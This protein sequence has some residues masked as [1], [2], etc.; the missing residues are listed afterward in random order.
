MR[1]RWL[2]CVCVFGMMSMH[3]ARAAAQV[4][5]V[6]PVRIAADPGATVTVAFRVRNALASPS[7]AS[8]SVPHGWPLVAPDADVPMPAGASMTRLVATV[9]PRGAAAGRYVVRY[10]AGA[11]ADSVL[12]AVAERRAV[13]VTVEEAPRFAVAGAPYAAAFRVTNR[14]NARASIRLSAESSLGFEARPDIRT[15]DLA[16]GET[17]IVR[18]AVTTKAVNGSATHR[19]ALRA[20]TDGAAQTGAARVT[21]VQRGTQ[22][23]MD[24][25]TLPVTVGL[26]AGPGMDGRSGLPAVVSASGALTPSTRVDLF[27]RGRGASAPDLGEQEQL[28]VSLRSPRGEVRF[29]DQYWALSPLTAP[30]RAGFGAGARVNAG[31]LWAEA[32]TARNRF[33]AGAPRVGGGTVGVHASSGSLALNYVPSSGDG[34]AAATSLR[35]RI[36]PARGISADAEYGV[37]DGAR[38]AIGR[39]LASRPRW[40]FDARAIRTD[41]AFPG[42]QAGRSLVQANGRISLP[43]RVRVNAGYEHELREDTFGLVLPG[44]R[45]EHASAYASVNLS[46]AVT[47][48]RRMQTREGIGTAGEFARRQDSWVASASFRARRTSFGGGVELGAVD[49]RLAG[50]SSPFQRTWL[51]AGTS[52]G[53][54][55]VAATVERRTG[56]NLQ[57]QEMDRMLGSVAMQ[58]QPRA[59]TR[60]SLFAQ[61]TANEWTDAPDGLVDGAI[62]RRLPGGHTIGLRVRAFPWSTFGSRKPQLYLDYAIP[63]RVPVGRTGETGLV[64]GRV[65]DTET[66]RPLP[67]VLVRVGDR[68]VLTDARGRWAVAGLA[69]GGYT[70]EI[71]PVSVG[72][73]RV[74]MRP[75]ALKVDVAGGRER[76]VEVGVSRAARVEGRIVVTDGAAGE[77]GVAGAVVEIRRGSERLRRVTDANGR[78]LVPGLAPG[79]WTVAM[80]DG[81]LPANHALEQ[82]EMPVTLA[83]GQSAALELRAVPRKREMVMVSGGEIVLGGAPV[84]ASPTIALA[85]TTR[86]ADAPLAIRP[87][88]VVPGLLATRPSS[89]STPS[90]SSAPAIPAR[91]PI[92]PARPTVDADEAVARPEMEASARPWR[93]RGASGLTDWPNDTYIVGEGDESLAA[94]AWLVY[95]DGDLWPKI[96][97]ANRSILPA[98][99][100]LRPGL[101]LIIPPLA[102]LTAEERAAARSYP[103]LPKS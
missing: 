51:R 71:D 44:T 80:V 15:I 1:L 21:L 84:S 65:M 68:A 89:A 64:S 99:D 18:V 10:R 26:R 103:H 7:P 11:F 61:A 52:A 97:L 59:D 27:Y 5:R 90:S 77:D 85:G 41:A 32:Y 49:D 31:P 57:G 93:E 9:V 40:G 58:L 81:D 48:E 43:A 92:A 72:V 4:E 16:A 28:T 60:L 42:D 83:A 53:I 23:N 6:G 55:S 19:I 38:G 54:G 69:P 56:G 2:A 8:A 36:E 94:I 46:N 24:A 78:F 20:E 70:V 37:A 47:V 34:S 82:R 12:I 25:R 39:L 102:P 17:R 13:A 14:G 3:P 95:R 22:R 79:E 63:L 87:T 76:A 100:R 96:W 29:G 33:L 88:S 30:G 75:D 62:E 101:E 35:A 86:R 67:D 66:N 50:S 91:R 45:L 74:L 73:G 98:P